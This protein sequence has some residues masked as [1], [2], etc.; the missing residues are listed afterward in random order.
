MNGEY[1]KSVV[2]SVEETNKRENLKIRRLGIFTDKEKEDLIGN[3][4]IF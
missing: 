1:P 2:D 3:A 4:T